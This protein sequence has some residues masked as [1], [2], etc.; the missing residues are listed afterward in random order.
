LQTFQMEHRSSVIQGCK[1]TFWVYLTAIMRSPHKHLN[2]KDIEALKG[3]CSV[4]ECSTPPE[5][6]STAD[7][8]FEFSNYLLSLSKT[9]D[10]SSCDDFEK[11]LKSFQ[12]R[13]KWARLVYYNNKICENDNSDTKQVIIVRSDL[14]MVRGK[15]DAQC[16]H[17]SGSFVFRQLQEQLKS[18]VNPNELTVKLSESEAEW[19]K[20]SYAKVVLVAHNEEELLELEE[21]ALEANLQVQRI[22]DAGRTQFKE[23]TLTCIA[24]GPDK[25]NKI[26][27]ITK[28]LRMR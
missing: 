6:K 26:D 10:S 18:G 21:K 23:P 22:V 14:K 15:E 1:E 3:L 8:L 24:I 5:L 19:V 11:V 27:P 17:A 16:S 20:N 28:H 4:I 9:I 12:I 25:I 7:H 2:S 13:A